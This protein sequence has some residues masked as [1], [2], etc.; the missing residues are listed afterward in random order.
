MR[1]VPITWCSMAR[2]R[3]GCRITK[4][5]LAWLVICSR[6]QGKAT[7]LTDHAR[8]GRAPM[9]QAG[10]LLSEKQGGIDFRAERRDRSSVPAT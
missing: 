3:S 2:S 6:T 1:P 7:V 5:D 4:A 9:L 8:R 10:R